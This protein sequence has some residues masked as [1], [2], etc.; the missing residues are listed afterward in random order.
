METGTRIVLD[1][2]TGIVAVSTAKY[3]A[4]DPVSIS[5]G[6]FF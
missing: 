6:I 3:L 1:D 4:L 5:I 2:G